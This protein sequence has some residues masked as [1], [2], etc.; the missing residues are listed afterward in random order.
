MSRSTA[1]KLAF[2][3]FLTVAGAGCDL[4]TK[5]WA[6]ESLRDLPNQTLSVV[7]PWLDFSLSYNRGTAFSIASDLGDLRPVMGAL[8]LLVAAALLALALR[9]KSGIEVAA[10]G[11]IAGGAIGNGFDRLFRELPEGGTAVVDFIRVNYPWGG[12]WPT[13]NIADALLAIGVPLLLLASL[14]QRP[15]KSDPE[16]A[17][18]P[19]PS[20][21]PA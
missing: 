18:S 3:V 17:S 7:A 1:T 5:A 6:V 14:Q 21:P 9:A 15:R 10:F 8:S 11:I 20:S 13:F 12:S 2:F 4:G 16:E 19:T